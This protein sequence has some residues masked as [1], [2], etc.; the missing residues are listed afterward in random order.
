M[1]TPTIDRADPATPPSPEAVVDIEFYDA[2][3]RLRFEHPGVR[4]VVV[5]SGKDKNFCAGANI[6]MLAQSSPRGRSTSTA[7]SELGTVDPG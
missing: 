2:T 7:P 6:R 5:T 4:A 3:Q 1:S